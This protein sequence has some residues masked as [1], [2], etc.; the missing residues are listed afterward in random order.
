MYDTRSTYKSV[1]AK[2]SS[3]GSFEHLLAYVY[4]TV[5][6]S[7]KKGTSSYKLLWTSIKCECCCNSNIAQNLSIKYSCQSKSSI[8]YKQKI[9]THFNNTTEIYKW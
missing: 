4:Y 1:F 8:K 9:Y 5:C 7:E 3:L 6:P 2:L